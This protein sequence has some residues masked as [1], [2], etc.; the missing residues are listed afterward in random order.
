MPIVKIRSYNALAARA[1]G[2]A[3]SFVDMLILLRSYLTHSEIQF[4]ERYGNVSYSS[5]LADNANGSRIKRINYAHPERWSTIDWLVTEEEEDLM[6][7]KVCE[8]SAVDFIQARDFCLEWSNLFSQDFILQGVDHWRYDTKGLLTFALN[9]SGVCWLDIL[10][11]FVWFW[12]FP[13]SP[14]KSKAW[15]SEAVTKV[16]QE[17]RPSFRINPEQT[18]PEILDREFRIYLK[19]S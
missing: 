18:S 9:K 1:Y 8:L 10:R 5:T 16:I 6:F 4:S 12:T 11:L 3:L 13:I 7:V 14:A 19:N 17:A 15:C 2:K